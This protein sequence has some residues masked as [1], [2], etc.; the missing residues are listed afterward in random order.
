MA[1]Q[2]LDRINNGG[3]SN[4]YPAMIPDEQLYTEPEALDLQTLLGIFFRRRWIA[5]AVIGTVFALGMIKTF[6][7]RP[8]Y[9]STAKIVVVTNTDSVTGS[10]RRRVKKYSTPKPIAP[11]AST[12]ARLRQP[13][14]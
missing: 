12:M 3:H 8:I 6:A 11:A 10:P 2:K 5:L 1:Q 9:E 14:K 7:Q 4:L 13:K